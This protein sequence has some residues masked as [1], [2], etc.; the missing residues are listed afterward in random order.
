MAHWLLLLLKLGSVE[1]SRQLTVVCWTPHLRLG[2]F[3]GLRL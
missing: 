2:G 1:T 3:R